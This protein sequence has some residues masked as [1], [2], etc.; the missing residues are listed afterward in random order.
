MTADELD[1]RRRRS[2]S[3]EILEVLDPAC[4]ELHQDQV[5]ATEAANV[6]IPEVAYGFEPGIEVRWQDVRPYLDGVVQPANADREVFCDGCNR[7]MKLGETRFGMNN[8]A[9]RSI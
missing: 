5:Q 8:V 6:Q 4:E 7:R 2:D 1:L 3:L 9:V